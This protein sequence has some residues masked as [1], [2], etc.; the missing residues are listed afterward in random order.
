MPLLSR[1][2]KRGYAKRT[3]GDP[4][5]AGK[6]RPKSAPPQRKRRV[7][8]EKNPCQEN[9]PRK[10]IA[11]L[12][13]K[14]FEDPITMEKIKAKEAACYGKQCFNLSTLHEMYNRTGKD[15]Y[16]EDFLSKPEICKHRDSNV[17]RFRRNS[18]QWAN[19]ACTGDAQQPLKQ[20]YEAEF[21]EYNNTGCKKTAKTSKLR[22]QNSCRAHIVRARRKAKKKESKQAFDEAL[23]KIRILD[24]Y[25]HKIYRRI[26]A[27]L[28][29]KKHRRKGITESQLRRKI[30]RTRNFI[31]ELTKLTDTYMRTSALQ[32]P[33]LEESVQGAGEMALRG[34]R[35]DIRYPDV[36]LRV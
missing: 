16:R 17:E 32:D 33:A 9:S 10:T 15:H 27:T 28:T 1:S 3:G 6:K 22:A 5:Y 35:W 24:A 4:K 26:H 20:A 12:A 25:I 11:K 7:K 18:L 34:L 14:K 23:Q 2:P 13:C 8:Q 36:R 29:V 31:H 19:A 21:A 30:T